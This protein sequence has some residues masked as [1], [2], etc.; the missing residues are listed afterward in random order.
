VSLVD[1]ARRV[2]VLPKPLWW[3]HNDHY[4]RLL[5]EQVPAGATRALDVGC[6]TGRFARALASRVGHVDAIDRSHE[7]LALARERSHGITNISYVDADLFEF[8]GDPRGYDFISLIAV[9]HHMDFARAGARLKELLAPGGVLAVLG[10]A[11]EDTLPEYARSGATFLANAAV[12]GW[13]ALRRV[14]GRP[15]PIGTGAGA[16]PEAPV[17]DP[18]MTFREARATSAE[19]FPGSRY[20]RLFWW[21]YLL[22]FRRTS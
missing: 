9:I 21:R 19:L 22:T 4:H 13:L 8:H 14:T 11:R 5:L 10:I 18:S 15:V 2:L 17:M 6:G 7:T 12:G 20:R 3:S 1:V 16:A